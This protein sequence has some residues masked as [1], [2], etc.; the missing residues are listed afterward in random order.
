M[1]ERVPGKKSVPF[2][3]SITQDRERRLRALKKELT[4]AAKEPPD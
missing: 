4:S 2:C 1:A 3:S